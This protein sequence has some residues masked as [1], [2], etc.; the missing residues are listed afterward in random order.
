MELITKDHEKNFKEIEMDYILIVTMVI[1]V[2]NFVKIDKTIQLKIV[3]FIV[4]KLYLNK[5]ALKKKDNMGGI[6]F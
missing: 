1:L 3:N 6:F 2:N 5:P 4:C